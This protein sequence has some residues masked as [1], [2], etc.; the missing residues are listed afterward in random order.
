MERLRACRW[1]YLQLA[2]QLAPLTTITFPLFSIRS[3]TSL[4]TLG[5]EP[6]LCLR[7]ASHLASRGNMSREHVLIRRLPV[8]AQVT[9]WASLLF[10]DS[11]DRLDALIWTLG[12]ANR[13]DMTFILVRR[14][15]RASLHLGSPTDSYS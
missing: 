5:Q 8:A 12:G 7:L 15:C 9:Q 1:L 13:R 2:G 3:P 6:T 10:D 11:R 4:L 14:S